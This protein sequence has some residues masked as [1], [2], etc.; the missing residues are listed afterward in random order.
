[1]QKNIN[2]PQL[3]FPYFK[4]KSLRLTNVNEAF[5]CRCEREG[6]PVSSLRRSERPK[7]YFAAVFCEAF[8]E[9]Q[10]Q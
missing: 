9:C 1:M 3:V 7:Q 10:T 5:C 2:L 8:K 6:T 4:I